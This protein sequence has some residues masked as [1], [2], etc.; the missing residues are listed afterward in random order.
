MIRVLAAIT[1][2]ALTTLPAAAAHSVAA[3]T[4]THSG[5]GVEVKAVYAPPEY[6]ATAKDP[7]GVQR[8]RPDTQLV[9]LLT[10]DTHAGDLTQYDVLKN[11]RLRASAG[12][13]Y[14]PVK[15]ESTSN[16]SH[17]RAGA[18]I[19]PAA[20]A[21]GKVIGAGV[22]SITLLIMNLAGVPVRVLGWALPIP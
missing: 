20:V 11:I 3:Y 13:E 21:G 14:A 19:F 4:R 17:H 18:L 9:F 5:G 12:K 7:N 16:D 8:F 2:V 22:T 1:L 6:F 10:F 15:W